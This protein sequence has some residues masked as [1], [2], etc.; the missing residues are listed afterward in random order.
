MPPGQA[1]TDPQ[2]LPEEFNQYSQEAQQAAMDAYNGALADD[3]SDDEAFRMAHA[4]A[5]Q[6]DGAEEQGISSETMPAIDAPSADPTRD[7]RMQGAAVARNNAAGPGGNDLARMLQQAQPG[8]ARDATRR[9][10]RY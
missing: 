9:R 5:K 2:D 8:A 4:A 10:P 1:Y 6:I 3:L 7:G